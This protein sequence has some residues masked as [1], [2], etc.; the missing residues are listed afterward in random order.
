MLWEAVN[1]FDDMLTLSLSLFSQMQHRV[2][3][4]VALAVLGGSVCVTENTSGL[5]SAC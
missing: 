2:D 1:S 3:S 4:L 5:S